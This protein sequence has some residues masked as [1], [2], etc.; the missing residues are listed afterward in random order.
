MRDTIKGKQLRD[1]IIDSL[2]D[3]PKDIAAYT[4]KTFQLV[5]RQ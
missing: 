1:F 3:H 4:A 2:P 5:G